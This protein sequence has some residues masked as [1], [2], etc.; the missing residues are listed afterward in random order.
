MTNETNKS[1]LVLIICLLL[2]AA[3]LPVYWQVNNHAFI[4][5]DDDKYVT[6]NSHVQRG[7]GADSIAWAFTSGHAQNWHPLTWLSHMLDCQLFGLNP[8]PHHL[9]SVFFHIVNAVLL[10]FVLKRATSALWPSAAVAALFALHP[11]HVESVAWV[12][13]RKD[14]LSTF[15]WILT[16]WAYIKY[17]EYANIGRYLLVVILFALGL[18]AKPMLVTLPI[19]LLAL[20]YWPLRRMQAGDGVDSRRC[21]MAQRLLAE[22]IPL[23][24]LAAMSC[25]V[26][27]LVQQSGGAVASLVHYPFGGRIANALVVYIA[28]LWKMVWPVHLAVFYPYPGSI[29]WGKTAAACVALVLISAFAIKN[30]RRRPYLIIGWLWYVVTLVPVIGIVQVGG[31]AMADRYTYVPLI[32]IFIIICFGVPDV[33]SRWRSSRPALGAVTIAVLAVLTVMSW[34]QVRRWKDSVTLFR[35]ALEVTTDNYMA[36][37]NLGAAL[38]DQGKSDEALN[39]YVKAVSIAPDFAEAR[40]NLGNAM[41]EQGRFDEAIGHYAEALKSS[42]DW[43]RLHNNLG[44]ALAE[45]GRLDDAIEHY[46]RAITLEPDYAEAR[47]NL[48]LVLKAQGRFEEALGQYLEG[49]RIT[50][51]SAQLHNDLAIA[52]AQQGRFDEAITHYKDVLRIEPDSA[53]VHNNLGVALAAL[54]RLDEA[55]AHYQ[56]ALSIQ[57]RYA[58]A[59]LNLAGAY[60]MSGD[61]DKAISTYGRIAALYP[62]AYAGYY[63]IARIYAKLK[64]AE[65]SVAWLER[66]VER[67]FAD[68][69]SL[70]TN[71]DWDTI[72]S[73][74]YYTELINRHQ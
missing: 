69:K 10:F 54:G 36:H 62:D 15:F 52:L 70:K 26:T 68:W 58:Q 37:T 14:V 23:F 28:Y 11:L 27:F 5:Y 45:R 67:G 7:L 6:E 35:H 63:E 2:I 41:S 24:V 40:F 9:A 17:A 12:S 64:R 60:D 51:D 49:L 53:R 4:N 50:P 48:G 72:R 8:G 19:V 42:P 56:K 46:S 43:A 61:Y 74:P 18:M 29:P 66:A 55:I 32:G 59:L 71:S 65:E 39:H 20:D 25:V 1:G 47:H 38:K 30:A 34:F 73:T 21:R 33:A 44:I 3:T 22:K 13:E 16:M 31:Q 57:P